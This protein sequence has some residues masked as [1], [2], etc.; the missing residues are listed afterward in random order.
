MQT[1]KVK[2]GKLV[3]PDL[4]WAVAK[5]LGWINYPEDSLERGAYWHTDLERAPFG[6][7][8]RL[9]EW[10]PS[11]DM[12]QGGKLLGKIGISLNYRGKGDQGPVSEF[13]WQALH[14]TAC[15]HSR[16]VAGYGPDFLT[17]AMRC[18]ALAFFGEH[19]DIP[20]PESLQNMLE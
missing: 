2:T 3:G 5:A 12:N 14:P 10:N 20:T 1:I 11:T 4:N 17:A 15:Y 9:S 7:C 16:K 13:D 19:I 18:I 8:I 6:K